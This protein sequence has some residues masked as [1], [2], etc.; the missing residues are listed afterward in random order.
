MYTNS[1]DDGRRYQKI[2][3]GVGVEGDGTTFLPQML[4]LRQSKIAI[5][6]GMS[7]SFSVL[8]VRSS[9]IHG[10]AH[11][12]CVC[13]FCSRPI[14]VSASL[15][16]PRRKWAP[17]YGAAEG[18]EQRCS[19]EQ[20]SHWLRWDDMQGVRHHTAHQLKSRRWEVQWNG[21]H[22]MKNCT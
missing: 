22:H 20:P 15:H 14:I 12:R 11:G 18:L 3:L 5:A 7:S 21:Y 9:A 10:H 6:I 1:Q 13:L 2:I 4:L 16:S 19:L 17:W 8:R